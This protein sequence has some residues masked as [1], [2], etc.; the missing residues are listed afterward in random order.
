MWELLTAAEVGDSEAVRRLLIAGASL[1]PVGPFGASALHVAARYGHHVVVIVLLDAA[2]NRRLGARTQEST[3]GRKWVNRQTVAG[4]TA[5]HEACGCWAGA[6]QSV[7]RGTGKHA[8]YDGNERVEIVEALLRAGAIVDAPDRYGTTPL[9]SS[10][11]RSWPECVRALLH[12]GANPSLADEL[13]LTPM[14]LCQRQLQRLPNRSIQLHQS[15]IKQCIRLLR[16]ETDEC[17]T[18]RNLLRAKQRLSWGKSQQSRLARI[19]I[20][21]KRFGCPAAMLADDL[22]ESV[23]LV[24]QQTRCSR[25]ALRRYMHQLSVTEDEKMGSLAGGGDKR[26]RARRRRRRRKAHE[27]SPPTNSI[28]TDGGLE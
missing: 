10:C 24:L 4:A 11:R 7:R 23:G 14:E 1:D 2:A 6:P 8:D 25:R 5:L 19:A 17:R 13:G 26:Q 28:A 16:E 9:L 3:S 15:A 20:H 27:S 21:Q 22:V 18:S 12:A